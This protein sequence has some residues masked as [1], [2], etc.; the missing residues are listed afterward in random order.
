MLSWK[1]EFFTDEINQMIHP[2]T[3]RVRDTGNGFTILYFSPDKQ[4]QELGGGLTRGQAHIWLEGFMKGL[5]V[6]Q[7]KAPIKPLT[8]ED[9]DVDT[10]PPWRTLRDYWLIQ[11][12]VIFLNCC[13]PGCGIE[14]RDRPCPNSTDRSL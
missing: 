3:V 10:D 14:I 9:P 12:G 2:R 4:T 6:G 11:G 5:R 13:S 1:F 7:G 8:F